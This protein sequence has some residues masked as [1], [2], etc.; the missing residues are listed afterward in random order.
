MA[1]AS[2]PRH[3]GVK[4]ARAT[5][6]PNGQPSI[7]GGPWQLNSHRSKEKR[8]RNKVFRISCLSRTHPFWGMYLE[9][10]SDVFKS[11][12]EHAPE[13]R[14]L[15]QLLTDPE[16]ILTGSINGWVRDKS[17]VTFVNFSQLSG[18]SKM[19]VRVLFKV[20]SVAANP[21]KRKR[22]QPRNRCRKLYCT[23]M[24]NKY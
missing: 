7:L 5:R 22:K 17:A 4:M 11:C 14:S 21:R 8:K 23:Y 9:I 15:Q 10:N 1:V 13:V 3:F 16:N 6:P 18:P 2:I 12:A 20:R 24:S 19:P